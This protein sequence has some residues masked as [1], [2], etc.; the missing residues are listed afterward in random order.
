LIR[1]I[2][3]FFCFVCIANKT[4]ELKKRKHSGGPGPF[5]WKFGSKRLLYE[6]LYEGHYM[7]KIKV[8]REGKAIDSAW[9]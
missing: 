2:L 1:K 3:I 6:A 7:R 5:W 8:S 9:P 4:N